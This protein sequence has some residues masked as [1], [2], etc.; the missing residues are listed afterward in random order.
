MSAIIFGTFQSK[1]LKILA[2]S[3]PKILR[4]IHRYLGFFLAG[5]M[6]MYALSGTVLIFRDTDFLKQEKEYKQ[7]LNAGLDAETLGKELKI[8]QLEFTRTEGDIAFWKD[9]SYNKASGKAVFTKKELPII[10]QKMT[11][12]HKAK[13]GQPLFFLNI[14]FAASLLFFVVSA[15]WMY[16]PRTNIFKRGIYF[17]LAGMILTVVLLWI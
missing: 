10:I 2:S 17:A 15:F 16:R 14:F 7:K 6:A 12:L 3:T 13:S 11:G 4:I 1:T 9:G 5:I 8:K